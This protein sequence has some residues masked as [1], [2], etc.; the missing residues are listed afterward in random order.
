MVAVTVFV[1][2]SNQH[3]NLSTAEL[4]AQVSELKRENAE[5]AGKVDDLELKIKELK[6]GMR[7]PQ[8][9]AVYYK[10]KLDLLT[11]S[12]DNFIKIY[13]DLVKQY[14]E[15]NLDPGDF[16]G[17]DYAL[18]F[19]KMGQQL[20]K[21]LARWS[22]DHAL[23]YR[24]SEKSGLDK[25]D[26]NSSDESSEDTANGSFK[27]NRPSLK[28]AFKILAAITKIKDFQPGDK[29]SLEKAILE[30][31][32]LELKSGRRAKAGS[33][34]SHDRKT[35]ARAADK[36]K[37]KKVKREANK[38]VEKCEKCGCKDLEKVGSLNELV[39]GL[40]DALF[41]I[42][43]QECVILRC[44]DCNHIVICS[45]DDYDPPT[46]P[47]GSV[48]NSI[49]IAAVVDE[50]RGVPENHANIELQRHFQI[51]N[52]TLP[53]TSDYWSENYGEPLATELH[54]A[55]LQSTVVMADETKISILQLQGS[56]QPKKEIRD[57]PKLLKEFLAQM[58][59]TS[60]V[61]VIRTPDDVDHPIILYYLTN[62]RKVETVLA[63]LS[64][65][66]FKFLV[67]DALSIYDAIVASLGVLRQSCL[68]HLRRE[69]LR[70]S[71]VEKLIP[72]LEDLSEEEQG[73]RLIQAIKERDGTV[74]LAFA[75]RAIS[76]L[77]ELESEARRLTKESYDAHLEKVKNVRIKVKECFDKLKLILQ[78]F[79]N[80]YAEEKTTKSGKKRY[81]KKINCRFAKLAVYY[82]KHEAEF[83]TFLLDGAECVPSHNNPTEGSVRA[84]SV[85]RNACKFK[86]SVQGAKNTCTN[87]SIVQTAEE[88]GIVDVEGYLRDYSRA[89]YLYATSRFFEASIKSAAA[90]IPTRPTFTI[91]DY[92]EGFDFEPWLPWNYLARTQQS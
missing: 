80:M 12:A 77:Y 60:F 47:T 24:G 48:G 75:L 18:A 3:Q 27:N 26:E 76:R 51:G 19:L 79:S 81:V 78:T 43:D 17:Q 11:V 37:T 45:P 82:L 64:G 44:K 91:K 25:S 22:A 83:E 57:N 56:H 9:S 74:L 40:K 23:L 63:L 2:S 50:V 71:N 58:R 13:R 7:A 39:R 8:E 42:Y 10:A 14:K 92:I 73:T 33:A 31:A 35:R 87:F 54:K 16:S 30:L 66:S 90:C 70:V 20:S 21:M 53:R 55:V 32:N 38:K 46:I 61:Q 88:C 4:L 65:G 15:L 29:D 28:K 72:E 62:D 59:H 36:P 67:S 49:T 86:V 1:M 84:L 69:I 89:L 6:D 41:Q 85:L 52:D 5:L 68:V 34:E